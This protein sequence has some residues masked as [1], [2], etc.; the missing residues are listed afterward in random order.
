MKPYD[1]FLLRTRWG[2][3]EIVKEHRHLRCSGPGVKHRTPD[4]EVAASRFRIL[5]GPRFL[6]TLTFLDNVPKAEIHGMQTRAL[7]IRSLAICIGPIPGVIF[8]QHVKRL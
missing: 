6:V 7:W 8:Y 4:T 1:V 5:S 3:E 2:N